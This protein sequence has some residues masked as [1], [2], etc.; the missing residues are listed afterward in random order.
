MLRRIGKLLSHPAFRAEPFAVLARAATWAGCVATGHRPVFTL[1]SSGER[2][3]V[4][5]DMRYTSVATFLLRDWTEPE[6]RQL[7][8]WMSV[9]ISGSSV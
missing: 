1:T 6:L 7:C 8:S 4:P 3:R 9:P 5:A 2:L